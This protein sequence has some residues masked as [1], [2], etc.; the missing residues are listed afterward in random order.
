MPPRYDLPELD[1]EVSGIK[2]SYLLKKINERITYLLDEDHQI[3]HSYFININSKNTEEERINALRFVFKNKIIPLLKEY[4]YNDYQKIGLVLGEDFITKINNP[5]KSGSS[6]LYN[7]DRE[8]YRLVNIDSDW[9]DD[10]KKVEFNFIESL[11][12]IVS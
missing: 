12:K 1:I 8:V 11:K 2:I 3:G 9:K 5:F 6:E 10:N 4:F 7:D